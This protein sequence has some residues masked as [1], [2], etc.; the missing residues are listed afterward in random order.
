MRHLAAA[1]LC[2]LTSSILRAAEAPIDAPPRQPNIVFFFVDDMGWQD[3]SVAFYKE[4]TELNDRYRT[5][6]MQTLA[7][8]GMMFTQAYACSLCSPSRVSLMTGA[9]AAR[10]RVTNWTLRE[11]LSPDRSLKGI[12]LPQWNRNGLAPV[13]GPT[14]PLTYAA[15]TLP[16]LLREAG[17]RTIHAGKAHWGAEGTPGAD[18]LNLG[19]DV[20]IAGHAAGGPG[21]YDGLHDF[22]AAWR[23]GDRIWDVPGLDK[24]HGKDINLTEAL[25]IEALAAMD[26]AVADHKPFYLYLAHYAVH[27]PIEADRRFVEKYRAAGLKG[28]QADYASMIEGMDQSLGDVLAHLD[29]LGI[30]DNTIVVFMSDNGTMGALPGPKPLRGHKLDPYEGGSRVPLIVRW[31]GV[32]KPASKCEQYVMIEDLFPTFLDMAHV[33]IPDA[34]KPRVD[35]LSFVPLLRS[36]TMPGADTRPLYWH[37]PHNYVDP[38]FSAIRVGPWKLIYHHTN[39][40]I[41]LFNLTSDIGEAHDVASQNPQIV[42]QLAGKLGKYLRSVGAD[43]PIDSS[44][45]KPIPWPDQR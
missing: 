36:E 28:S 10:H 9:N 39:R 41:E 32:T 13:G 19:F 2:L 37:F 23:K 40:V 25:T 8:G 24:Y 38:P 44:T 22:S 16:Q 18:P 20:N 15:V 17:Y 1:L 31:P 35:G 21:S 3:T 27:A 11:N 4:R 12:E 26:K 45:Q 33:P 7:D 30:A 29:K 42:A 14:T 6:N 5:P 34:A 43:M